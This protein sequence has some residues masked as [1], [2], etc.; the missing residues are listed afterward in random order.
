M[1]NVSFAFLSI[2]IRKFTHL[3]GKVF[4]IS[5]ISKQREAYIVTG[6]TVQPD[7]D[8]GVGHVGKR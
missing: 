1:A 4:P 3:N 7:G 2:T 5:W 6:I 8:P